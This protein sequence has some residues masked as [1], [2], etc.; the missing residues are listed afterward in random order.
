MPMCS[1]LQ[2]KNARLDPPEVNVHEIN[3][4]ASIKQNEYICLTIRFNFVFVLTNEGGLV[5]C[6]VGRSV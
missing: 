5:G 3:K 1:G 2:G 4:S 6:I